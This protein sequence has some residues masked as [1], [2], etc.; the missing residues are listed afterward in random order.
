MQPHKDL[1]VLQTDKEAHLLQLFSV[2]TFLPLKKLNIA[3]LWEDKD[4]DPLKVCVPFRILNA[5]QQSFVSWECDHM[6]LAQVQYNLREAL[7]LFI[8]INAADN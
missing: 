8:L 7:M 1:F 6:E 2:V 4:R 5:W 3:S